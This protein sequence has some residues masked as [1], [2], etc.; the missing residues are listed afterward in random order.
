MF[1]YGD[2]FVNSYQIIKK[3]IHFSFKLFTNET[4]QSGIMCTNNDIIFLHRVSYLCSST[5]HPCGNHAMPLMKA[6]NKFSLSLDQINDGF[7]SD[8]LI[9]QYLGASVKNFRTFSKLFHHTVKI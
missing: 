7:V 5:A 3:Q 9:V 2:P 8:I 1:I 4:V 6:S